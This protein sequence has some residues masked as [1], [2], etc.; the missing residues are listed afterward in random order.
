MKME[1][2]RDLLFENAMLTEGSHSLRKLWRGARTNT[3]RAINGVIFV[4][5]AFF[6]LWLCLGVTNYPEAWRPILPYVELSLIT[7]FVPA[8]IYGAVAN[9]RERATWEALILTRLTPG[10]ILFGK[11]L[12]RI[13]LI[14]FIAALISVLMAVNLLSIPQAQMESGWQGASGEPDAVRLHPWLSLFQMQAMLL[15][16]GFLLASFGL[17][18]SSGSRRS[19]TAAA[20]TFGSL[21]GGLVLLPALFSMI[22]AGL[23]SSQ[24]LSGDTWSVVQLLWLQYNPF[25]LIAAVSISGAS[26][27]VMLADQ[28]LF[29]YPGAT[30][31]YIIAACWLIYG[32]HIRLRILEEP[33]RK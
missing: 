24:M 30:L 19:V 1:A 31:M 25:Y 15:A 21:M 16:W 8:S 28:W 7:L 9:E 27:G 32:A 11:L 18:V 33:K 5:I 12:W 29:A 23:Q 20:V 6:Y 2:L 3:S 22:G 10:Q 17:W 26:S 4:L 14:L 13:L